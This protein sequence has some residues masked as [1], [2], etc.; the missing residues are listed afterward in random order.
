[1][2]YTG[3][4]YQFRI[5]CR[6]W[7]A[8]PLSRSGADSLSPGSGSCL[9]RDIRPCRH[10]AVAGAGIPRTT[11]TAV[12]GCH[13]FT[14]NCAPQPRLLPHAS[15]RFTPRQDPRGAGNRETRLLELIQV[16]SGASTSSPASAAAVRRVVARREA[17]GVGSPAAASC[18]ACCGAIHGV[19]R[20]SK[21]G[22]RRACR[23]PAEVEVL[24][25]GPRRG[26]DL[27]GARRIGATARLRV[28]AA[29]ALLDAL[30]DWGLGL[31]TIQGFGWIR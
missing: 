7:C 2:T 14:V 31:H 26:F 16:T 24:G 17:G 12:N 23:S 25:A 5:I 9:A 18:P 10:H 8:C 4:K 6:G 1:M 13:A 30:Y 19:R 22:I 3:M 29:S 21:P 11:R 20:Y 28:R 15:I 27:S